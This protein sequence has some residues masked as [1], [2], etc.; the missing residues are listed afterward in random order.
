MLRLLHEPVTRTRN[1]TIFDLNPVE[2]SDKILTGNDPGTMFHRKL[3]QGVKSE[4]RDASVETEQGD[5][6][7]RVLD[8]PPSG[9]EGLQG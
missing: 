6:E 9:G 4:I 2:K 1:L 7:D 8:A 3:W 5:C